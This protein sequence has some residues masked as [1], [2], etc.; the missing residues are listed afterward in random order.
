MLG[1]SPPTVRGTARRWSLQEPA[2]NV[3]TFGHG[4]LATGRPCSS[5]HCPRPPE[6]R[7]RHVWKEKG[8]RV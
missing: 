2:L 7:A 8:L 5:Q 3:P 4:E 6:A 1:T